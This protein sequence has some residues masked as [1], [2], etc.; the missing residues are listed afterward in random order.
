MVKS[1]PPDFPVW[2]SSVISE[3]MGEFHLLFVSS[4]PESRAVQ[5]LLISGCVGIALTDTRPLSPVEWRPH[6]GGPQWA[7]SSLFFRSLELFSLTP[8]WLYPCC[9]FC[10]M[11]ASE[12]SLPPPVVLLT[13]L[14]TVKHV[15]ISLFMV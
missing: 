1:R 2:A 14:L 15:S 10:L 11:K 13:S 4:S 6:K 7:L 9:S 5:L 8:P 12:I 3:V